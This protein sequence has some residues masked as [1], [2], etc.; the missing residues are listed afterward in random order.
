M[1]TTDETLFNLSVDLLCIAEGGYFKKLSPS[2]SDTLGW[3]EE[4]LLS[5]PYV[6]FVHPEDRTKTVSETS[7]VVQGRATRGFENRYRTKWGTYRWLQWTSAD[8]PGGIAAVARD[9]TAQKQ[10]EALLEESRRHAEFF[11][12]FVENTHD[13]FYIISP[14]KGF[15]I[16]YVNSAACA[17]Y[18]KTAQ[19]LLRMSVPDF[20]PNYDIAALEALWRQL[21]EHK[22]LLLDTTHNIGDGRVIPV[23][24]SASYLKFGPE[25]YIAGSIRDVTEQRRAAENLERFAYAVSHDL[26]EPLRTIVSYLQLMED[27]VPISQEVKEYIEFTKDAARRM[28]ALIRG[29]LDYSRVGKQRASQDRNPLNEI[30]DSAISNLQR[31]ISEVNAQITR[32]DLPAVLG[33]STLLTQL[34]QNLIDNAIKY[35]SKTRPKIHIGSKASSESGV[36]IYVTDQGIGIPQEHLEHVFNAF[37]RLHTRT[38]YPGVGIGLATCKKVVELHGGQIWATSTLGQGSTFHVTLPAATSDL[39][40][41]TNALSFRAFK[42]KSS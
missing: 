29:L 19:E 12:F 37:H 38:E 28:R 30:V 6:E 15:R 16:V 8:F 10:R 33:D 22:T 25:E 39:L 9:V 35:S 40:D 5:K 23:E 36:E 20:D 31:K 18:Q 32:E 42:R 41:Q 17:H 3:S 1:T 14:M 21:K 7:R 34:F 26:Q 11:Q 27:K 2:W 4:E 24:V 13:P